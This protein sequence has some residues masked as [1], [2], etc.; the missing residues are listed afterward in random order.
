M[1]NVANVGR[2][3]DGSTSWRLGG[4]VGKSDNCI[5]S[6]DGGRDE[7]GKPDCSGVDG[8]TTCSCVDGRTTCTC[9]DGRTTGSGD[10]AST[11]RG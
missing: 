9:V 5:G 3:V 4:D 6:I 2:S 11:T 7:Q 8:R 1:K 10:V